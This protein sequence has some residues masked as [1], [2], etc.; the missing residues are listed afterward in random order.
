MGKYLK[1]IGKNVYFQELISSFPYKKLSELI[2]KLKNVYNLMTFI[3]K[4]TAKLINQFKTFI[5]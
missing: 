2:N 3:L 1:S 5:I 4:N